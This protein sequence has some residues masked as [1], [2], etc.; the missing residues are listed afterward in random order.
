MSWNGSRLETVDSDRYKEKRRGRRKKCQSERAN[1]W[2]S[3]RDGQPHLKPSFW[4]VQ[5]FNV[6]QYCRDENVYDAFF[7]THILSAGIHNRP[8]HFLNSKWMDNNA[9]RKKQTKK[10]QVG[11]FKFYQILNIAESLTFRCVAHQHTPHVFMINT[12]KMAI[13][14]TENCWKSKVPLIG[15]YFYYH[16]WWLMIPISGNKCYDFGKHWKTPEISQKENIAT[17]SP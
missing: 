1:W 17:N 14:T 8:S 2:V 4:H 5:M 11:N 12:M 9:I 7:K 13:D 15:F 10:Q 16:C 6:N 3:L